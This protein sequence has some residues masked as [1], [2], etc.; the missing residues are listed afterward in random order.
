[1]YGQQAVVPLEFLVP[2]LRVE[3]ITNMTEQGEVQEMLSQMMEMEEDRIV[4]R[5][6]QEVHK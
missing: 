6:H 2:S 3:T 1:V 4:A 5:F